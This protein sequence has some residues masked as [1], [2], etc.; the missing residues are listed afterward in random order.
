MHEEELIN[1]AI[2]A[3]AALLCGLLL[4]R[5]KQPVVVGYIIAGVVLG[6]SVLGLVGNGDDLQL[7]AELGVLMLLFLIW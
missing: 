7:V 3:G 1:L 2:V 5:I 6:P 4:S